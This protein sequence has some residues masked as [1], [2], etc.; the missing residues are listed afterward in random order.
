MRRLHKDVVDGHVDEL[1][2]EA[3]ETHES[4]TNG[5]GLGDLHEFY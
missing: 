2:E 5:S 3:N 4:E 1:N